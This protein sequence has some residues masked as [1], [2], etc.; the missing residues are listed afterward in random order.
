[1]ELDS[2]PLEI[3]CDTVKSRL[4]G[5]P[6]HLLLDCRE[7]AEYDTVHIDGATLLPMSELMV[8]AEELRPFLDRPLSVYCH[9]G[10]RSRQVVQWLRQQGYQQAQ[11][12][13]GGIEAWAQQIEPGMQRY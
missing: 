5:D 1:M 12:M 4:D 8:R 3:D 7:Q 13:S 2:L 10:G 11:S 9:L 6:Q